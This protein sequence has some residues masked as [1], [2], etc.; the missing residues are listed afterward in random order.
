MRDMNGDIIV[1]CVSDHK[2]EVYSAM[3]EICCGRGR[4]IITTLDIPSCLKATY[5]EHGPV[6]QD[7]MNESMSTFSKR[8]YNKA[9][10]TGRRLML[11]LARYAAETSNKKNRNTR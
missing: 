6:D 7:G 2:K 11:N 4:V 1:A 5:K 10:V 9:D 8:L 3:S